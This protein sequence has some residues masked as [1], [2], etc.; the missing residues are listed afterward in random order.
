[1]NKN[2]NEKN[3]IGCVGIV[4][5]NYNQLYNGT[6]SQKMLYGNSIT[7]SI[8]YFGTNQIVKGH[9]E[10]W[11]RS[12][13]EYVQNKP[14]KNEQNSPRWNPQHERAPSRNFNRNHNKE[15]R[16]QP[17]T[18]MK[19]VNNQ[20]QIKNNR[21][22]NN[23]KG[24]TEREGEEIPLL[25]NE[26]YLENYFSS[27][28]NGYKN[29]D[30]NNNIGYHYNEDHHNQHTQRGYSFKIPEKEKVIQ[31]N[32]KSS[33]K[34]C[35]VHDN[36][37][38]SLL[39][40]VNKN[41]LYNIENTMCDENNK[42]N[43]LYRNRFI[44]REMQKGEE[45]I[46]A[47][48]GGYSKS[49]GVY[50][51]G[52]FQ[53]STTN[54]KPNRKRN[55]QDMDDPYNENYDKVANKR[56]SNKN[57]WE[58]GTIADTYEY[59]NIKNGN[60][61][62][63]RNSHEV[64]KNKNDMKHLSSYFFTPQLNSNSVVK[65]YMNVKK[66]KNLQGPFHFQNTKYYGD[67]R[68]NKRNSVITNNSSQVME[69]TNSRSKMDE[70]Y[71]KRENDKKIKKE[72]S[73]LTFCTYCDKNIEDKDLD[74]HNKSEH[75]KCPID[76]CGQ[77]YNID[78]LEF[79]LLNHMKNEKNEIILNDSK[80]IEK[81]IEERK[82]NYPTRSKIGNIKNNKIA[83]KKKKK[84]NC[85]IEE[86]LFESYCSALGRNIYCKNQSEK[87]IFVP[88]LTKLEQN[89]MHNIYENNYYPIGFNSNGNNYIVNKKKRSRKKLQ[90]IDSLNIHRNSPL[91]YQ[92][93]KKEIYHYEKKL[94]KCIEY[95]TQS[96][97][98][99]DSVAD[100]PTKHILELD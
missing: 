46:Y 40:N 94:I 64:C 96:A 30:I 89:K 95:I 78:D 4:K 75:I 42:L 66:S 100:I 56:I 97:F 23:E 15:L 68:E 87:S 9:G 34:T 67:R 72:N 36:M 79:H 70:G 1:M 12:D 45:T 98:F 43:G 80:E 52:F 58:N 10:P 69:T 13:V 51:N 88:L 83:K 16:R 14:N 54:S 37:K 71:V 5:N 61:W 91:L 32:A 24:Y 74:E 85:L 22:R 2:A 20:N 25:S 82:K 26:N 8:N 90:L 76:N 31:Y 65:D 47:P 93:M 86:L 11:L 63:M 57:F 41:M 6:Q 35:D 33:Y 21:E 50:R 3:Y 49:R 84:P 59:K 27:Y 73:K 7:T 81:W 38:E 29:D 53:M 62:I 99:D 39:T 92:L 44:H 19:D 18:E 77:V 60:T 48:Q 17:G 28:T 55:I